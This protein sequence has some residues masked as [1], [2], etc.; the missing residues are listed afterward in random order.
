[1]EKYQAD[2]SENQTQTKNTSSTMLKEN[3]NKIHASEESFENSHEQKVGESF[4]KQGELRL[5]HG[6]P[7]GIQFFDLAIQLDPSNP[8]LYYSQGLSILEFASEPGR[9]KHLLIASKRF[10]VATQLRQN[11]FEAWNA[12]G[13]CLF[14]LG[15]TFG[16]H[17]YFL[18]AEQKYKKAL[19]LAFGQTDDVMSDLYWCY[20]SVWFYISKRSDEPSDMHLAL[21][22]FN[23]ASKYQDNLSPE[24]WHDFGD[25]CQKLGTKLNDLRFFFKAINCFKNA[26]SI[27]ISN[28]ES[29]LHLACSLK[30]L[31]GFTHDEDHFSQANEC[32][33]TAAQLKST[34]A[35]LWLQWAKILNSSGRLIK[36]PK[37]LKSA[38]EKCKKAENYNHNCPE[39]VAIWSEALT[40]LGLLG[41]KVDEIYE[42]QNMIIDV[43]DKHPDLPDLYHSL[44]FSFF[45]LG[46]YFHDLDY[47]Y[48]AIEK[49]QEGLS[50]DR[51]EHKL[52]HALGYCYCTIGQIE[53]DNSI[54]DRAHKFF[55]K[56][57]AIQGNS[58]YYYD[59]AY[60]LLKYAEIIND[61]KTLDLAR[62]NFEQALN[63]QKNAIYLHPDWLYNYGVTLDLLGGFSEDRAIYLKAL[64]VLNHVLMVDPDFPSIH[65]QLAIT[66][67][68]LAELTSEIPT[69]HKSLHYYRLA[70][71]KDEE[72]DAIILD[73]ALI[74]ISLGN[75]IEDSHERE[76]CFKDAEYKLTQAAKLGNTHA[77][78]HLSCLFSIVGQLEKAMLFLYKAEEFDALPS[79]NELLEDDWLEN[80]R[81]T[82]AFQSFFSYLES[83]S[84][85]N[86]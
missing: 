80:L 31:Y 70:H 29:W 39:V 66:C 15:K 73:W 17:H 54:F 85:I 43:I 82:P 42:A 22:A 79:S 13:N 37:R 83:Q 25:V 36:D 18:E 72:N 75:E 1:M 23:K 7:S 55:Q 44:G 58:S 24:F 11:Y 63:L 9:E 50:L 53:D 20:G 35:K 3:F 78:Y 12:W 74:L 30:T 5:L 26:V 51:T 49:F 47:Y 32:F 86:D 21:D 57:I 10:K 71:K 8:E 81:I 52:W 45:A 46:K 84:K 38:I 67:G 56:A 60:S 28:Y 59:F 4:L 65:Y 40:M 6:D 27:S 77:Y 68:H 62:L 16:E 19:T 76:L 34:D 2:Q 61:E 41:D 64:D 14:H 69:Y 33:S 48:Q